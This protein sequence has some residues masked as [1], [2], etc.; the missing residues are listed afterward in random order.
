VVN[1]NRTI[2]EWEKIYFKSF[3][4]ELQDFRSN[5]VRGTNIGK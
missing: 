3:Y 4:D 5:K 1:R 2:I